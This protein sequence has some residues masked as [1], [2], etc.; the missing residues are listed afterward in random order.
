MLIPGS[1]LELVPGRG[2][3]TVLWAPEYR[4]AA[5]RFLGGP[6]YAWASRG[7]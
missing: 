7:A 4:V 5:P 6:G 3:I 1:R 2:H